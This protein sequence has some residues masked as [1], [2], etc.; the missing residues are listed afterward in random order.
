MFQNHWLRLV[1]KREF[2]NPTDSQVYAVLPED[3][4]L[5]ESD[6]ISLCKLRKDAP[7]DERVI[8]NTLR[9]LD[10]EGFAKKIIGVHLETFCIKF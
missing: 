1:P 5:A 2:T 7:H 6:I 8:L 9:K 10:K 3:R 4:L